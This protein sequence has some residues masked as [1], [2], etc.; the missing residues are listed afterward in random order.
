MS[1]PR[2]S[3]DV[4]PITVAVS[5]AGG[6]IGYQ[7][8]FRLAAGGMFGGDRPIALRLLEHA[9]RMPHLQATAME[10]DDCAF[11]LLRQTTI[12]DDPRE[13]FA[14]ADWIVMLAGSPR[15]VPSPSRLDLL[16]RNGEIYVE[17]G[18]AVNS[19]APAAR[20]LVVAAPCNVNC[21]IAMNHAQ[22]VPREHWFALNRVN[23]MRAASLIA[24]QAEV[25]V[26]HVHGV[27]VW[28]NHGDR[29]YVDLHHAWIDGRPAGDFIT[30][31]QWARNTLQQAV[32]HRAADVFQRRG[33]APAATAAQAILGTVH[34]I[35]TP[36]PLGRSFAAAVA[37]DG[38]YGVPQGL[39]F[40]FPLRTEDGR[41]WSIVDDLY[42]DE[43]AQEQL[44]QNVVQLEQEAVM[45][46]RWFG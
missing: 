46:E 43:F 3:Q 10:L 39:I 27:T 41:T 1:E 6:M 4:D 15:D 21:M 34:S 30:D 2:R 40:G 35:V 9:W 37:S 5:G 44:A 20:I 36:T 12:T 22:D 23:Q 29:V 19:V 7:L 42:L 28:G 26:S 25:P 14:G 33:V 45:A 38:S 31:V 18:R 32:R 8:V 11:P 24:K 13:A 17:H 16:R